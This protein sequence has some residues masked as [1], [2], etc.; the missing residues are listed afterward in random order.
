MTDISQTRPLRVAIVGAGPAGFYAA[1]ALLGAPGLVAEVDLFER[2]PAPF[3]LVRF[4][5]APDHQRIKRASAAFERTVATE[6]CRFFGNVEVGRDVT[7][8]ELLDLYD[9][10]LLTTGSATDRKLGI[11]GEGL[12]GCHGAAAFVG[13]YNGHPDF[14]GEH[15][16]LSSQRAVVV[17]VGNVALDVT[18]ILVR[19]P[20]ELA[21]TD[22]TG[23]ALDAL[24]QSRVREVVVLG[25]RGPAEAAFDAQE[26][27]AIAGL[28]GVDVIVDPAEIAPALAELGPHA[29]TVREKVELMARLA[30]RGPSGAPRR[31]VLRFLASPVELVGRGGRLEAVRI[32][33]NEL[34]RRADGRMTARGAG[35]YE[36]LQTS[37]LL[38]SIGYQAVP[39]AGV[40][41]DLKLA[42]V[43]NRGGRVT[44]VPGGDVVPRMYVAGWIKRGPTGLIGTNKKD[45]LETVACMLADAPDLVG[46]AGLLGAI[47]RLLEQRGVK[48]V[49]AAE[50]RLLDTAEQQ[51]GQRLGKVREKVIGPENTWAAIER[52]RSV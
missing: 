11:V 52:A 35:R 24:R 51:A 36:T 37:L 9:Q 42:R 38:R 50:W 32:E 39:I 17:G 31:V 41:F 46:R 4:G 15:F 47:D 49:G 7:I 44:G 28:D 22:I 12:A 18:R 19:D 8:E 45:A 21:P 6:H 14:A 40:P 5:V 10:V 34:L 48:V 26:L 30:E 23:Y 16:D 25:R 3:G 43:P 1:A 29:H 20:D 27:A 33:R 13:W 2:L